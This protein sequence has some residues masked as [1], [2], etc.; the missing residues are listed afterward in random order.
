MRV[1]ASRSISLIDEDIPALDA[2]ELEDFVLV[3]GI[4]LKFRLYFVFIGGADDDHC[5]ALFNQRAAQEDEPFLNERVDEDS[6]LVP[7]WLLACSFGEIAVCTGTR[8]DQVG[9]L[10]RHALRLEKCRRFFAL[11][12][13]AVHLYRDRYPGRAGV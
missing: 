12:T 11:Y 8:D 6:V 4:V 7:E 10:Q 9:V 1:H 3:P 5:P 2:F 13:G